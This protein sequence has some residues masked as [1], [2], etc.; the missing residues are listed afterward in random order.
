MTTTND[1]GPAF[2]QLHMIDGNWQRSPD[3]ALAGMSLRAYFAAM[4]M[5]GLL[6]NDKITKTTKGRAL[7]AVEQADALLTALEASK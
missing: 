1:G 3:P 7:I 4:A 6:A 2:P 5:Q